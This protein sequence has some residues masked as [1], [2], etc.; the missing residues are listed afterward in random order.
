VF[1]PTSDEH[2]HPVD[3]DDA[4]QLP[5]RHYVVYDAA[6]CYTRSVVWL[7]SGL[8]IGHERCRNGR[9]DRWR[10]VDSGGGPR[11]HR[12]LVGEGTLCRLRCGLLLPMQ[13][14]LS[15]C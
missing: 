14:G 4:L 7:F 13:R 3:D 11:N 10:D 15:V 2:D 5:W 9:T 1:Y 12:A 8:S 6:Y